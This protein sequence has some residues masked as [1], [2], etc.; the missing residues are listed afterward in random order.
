MRPYALKYKYILFCTAQHIVD[1]LDART[2]THEKE[3][4]YLRFDFY[5]VIHRID[6][7]FYRRN[8][9]STDDHTVHGNGDLL[10]ARAKT[11]RI[12]RI[13]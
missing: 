8:R 1:L 11:S 2:H 10:Y 4:L 12:L 5:V 7:L 13:W 6:R 3:L 9:R